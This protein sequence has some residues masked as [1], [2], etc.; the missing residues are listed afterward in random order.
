MIPRLAVKCD[1]VPVM[2]RR[3]YPEI[4][5][6]KIPTKISNIPIFCLKVIEAFLWE[7]S[8]NTSPHFITL[9]K[10]PLMRNGPR[11]TETIE[12]FIRIIGVRV[13]KGIS[14]IMSTPQPIISAQ[15]AEPVIATRI[16]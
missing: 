2:L 16:Y 10:S 12:L 5:P 15:V 1:S 6:P 11:A 8:S 9:W 13:A 14:L 7:K 4:N 3:R